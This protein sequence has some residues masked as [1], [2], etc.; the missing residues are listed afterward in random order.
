MTVSRKIG[1]YV[2]EK[3][4][5]LSEI[6]RQTGISYQ[7]LYDSMY[8]TSRTRELRAN[9]LLPLCIFLNVDLRKFAGSKDSVLEEERK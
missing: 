3:G 8:G 6:S 4:Y 1:Q 7:C 2:K 9:E 5:N